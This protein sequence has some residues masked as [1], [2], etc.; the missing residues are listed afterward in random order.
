MEQPNS[1]DLTGTEGGG[2]A[3]LRDGPERDQA[4]DEGNV[5]VRLTGEVIDGQRGHD[6]SFSSRGPSK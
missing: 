4:M 6:P 1:A 3:L 2:A 5:D